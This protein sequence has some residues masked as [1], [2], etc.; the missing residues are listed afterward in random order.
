MMRTILRTIRCRYPLL[1]LAL[2]IAVPLL[3]LSSAASPQPRLTRWDPSGR[4][5]PVRDMQGWHQVFADN[6]AHDNVPVGAFSGCSWPRGT[7]ITRLQCMGLAPYPN[8]EAKWFAYPDNWSGTPP[9][10]IYEPSHVLSIQDGVMTY[11]IHTANGL[12]M[13]AAAVPKIPGGFG[14]VGGHR[15]GR[16]MVRARI[17]PLPGYH[18]SFLLWPD[19]GVWPRDR[20][21]DFPEANF[22]SPVVS[23]FVHWQDA[24]GGARQA[25]FS[26]ATNFSRWHTYEIDWAPR[27]CSFYL[28]GHIV[29][30]S[31]Q[32]PGTPMHWVLQA[33]TSFNQAAPTT[34][35]AGD[36]LIDWV[37]A[38]VRR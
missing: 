35:T 19:S 28:D 12:H 21:V 20:E 29:G 13:I 16:Y 3:V 26:V 4:A 33:G 24:L 22:D 32:S 11:H 1:V 23:G 14:P 31:A 10:G 18:A 6:F 17:D 9:T 15:H 5:M 7:P 30:R 37:T 38:F 25:S 34:A 2:L 8:V 36:V 27:V